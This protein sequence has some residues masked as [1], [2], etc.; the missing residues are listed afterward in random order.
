MRKSYSFQIQPQDVD[1]KYQVTLSA[2]TNILLTTA[3]Y[4]ADENGFGIRDLNKND[5]SWVLLRLALEMDSYPTQYETI[6]IE[7]WVEEVGRAT[8]TRNFKIL[9]KENKTIG[10]AISNW[11]M[12]NIYT[13][14]AQ[15]LMLLDGIQKFAIGEKIDMEKP[16]KLLNIV[17]NPIDV[18]KVKYSHIDINGHTSSMKYVEWICN[19]IDLD[20]YKIRNISRFEINFINEILYGEEVSIFVTD[21]NDFDYRFEIQKNGMTACRARIVMS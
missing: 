12:I 1:F 13:R 11:A 15:D 14:K 16:V 3:G 8:T 20:E 10:R 4:N 21:N 6:G 19:C 18:F 9:D 17:G 2:L 7:T 5:C